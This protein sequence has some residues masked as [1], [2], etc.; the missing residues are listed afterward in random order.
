MK[1]G[2]SCSLQKGTLGGNLSTVG[3]RCQSYLCKACKEKI[4]QLTGLNDLCIL[5]LNLCI[6][7]QITSTFT[8][9]Q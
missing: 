4:S 5:G 2:E 7:I 1:L 6:L 3:V 8:I 9:K